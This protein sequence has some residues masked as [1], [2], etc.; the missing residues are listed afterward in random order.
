L[1]VVDDIK[2]WLGKYDRGYVWSVREGAIIA[3]SNGIAVN[4]RCLFEK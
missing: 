2:L 3:I 4:T 1:L